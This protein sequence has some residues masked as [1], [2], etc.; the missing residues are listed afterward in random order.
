VGPWTIE[1]IPPEDIMRLLLQAPIVRRVLP[2]AAAILTASMA[3]I[4]ATA[5]PQHPAV[6]AAPAQTTGADS[7]RAVVQAFE[8][9]VGEYVALHRLLEGPLPPLQVTHD[10][11]AVRAAMEALA[12][13]IRTARPGA[14]QGDLFTPDVARV[15]RT[16]LATCLTPED[17]QALLTEG[18]PGEQ[19][20]APPL[21]VNMVWPEEVP[22]N[23]VPPQLIA[24]LP[25]LPPELQYRIIGRA[26]VLWDHHAN[27][28]VDYLPAAF[29]T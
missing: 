8:S 14:K 2:L 4:G 10:M 17:I 22:F 9:R 18:E 15:F 19:I 20:V 28:I 13:H 27:L 24:A 5:L 26:L 29:T 11:D 3:P 25:P 6:V 7:E 1:T 21:T 23:F 12:R 16:R